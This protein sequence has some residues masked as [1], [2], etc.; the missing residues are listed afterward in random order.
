[1][2]GDRRGARCAGALS[3]AGADP[4]RSRLRR[5]AR[6]D[7][8]RP[9]GDR[10]ADRREAGRSCGPAIARADRDRPADVHLQELPGR[11]RGAQRLRRRRRGPLRRARRG[12]LLQ[13]TPAHR[14]AVLYSASTPYARLLHEHLAA[15][16]IEVN[17]PGTRP[18]HERA[19]AR[20]LLEV[21][22]L[23][24]HDLP[25]ADLFRALANA[26]TRD[27]TGE[28]IP[29]PQWERLSRIAGVV[30][31]NDWDER[32]ARYAESE[33][34]TAEQEQAAEDSR[35]AAVIRRAQRN[36]EQRAERLHEFAVELRRRLQAAALLETWSEL[37]AAVLRAVPGAARRHAIRCRSRSSTRRSR[38][39]ARCAGCRPSTSSVRRPALTVLRDVL[40]LELQQSLPRVGHVRHRRTGRS[41]V[42]ERRAR[43]STSCSWSGCPRTCIPGGCTR[44]PCSP[45][46][47]GRRP[48]RSWLRSAIGSTRSN[49]T[50]SSRSRPARTGGR[51][52]PARRPAQLE[53]PAA[54]ALAARHACDR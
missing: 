7:R 54:D 15:A 16:K 44:T 17:G 46:G 25:R 26:P 50:C 47:F 18:V 41:V 1:M 6:D 28:R 9:D 53:P 22:A 24:D 3:P 27:F 52:V 33:R 20:T 13:R 43:R 23:V 48:R 31:G 51:V 45:T 2:P 10:R 36:A 35:P 11:D 21:L 19:L 38:S 8:G 40:D 4:G 42:R 12:R 5:G 32:L 37:A 49:G 29:V 14:I 39:R 30:R 34:R